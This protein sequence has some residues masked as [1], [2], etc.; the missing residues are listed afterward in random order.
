M[1]G[2]GYY[3][4]GT[5]TRVAGAYI[6]LISLPLSNRCVSC[7]FESKTGQKVRQAKFCCGFEPQTGNKRNKQSS[8][9]M[10]ARWVSGGKPVFV[11]P[12]D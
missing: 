11:F 6:A 7:G 9:C 10:C 4:H 3:M 2:W 1:T 12:T 8:V 5:P